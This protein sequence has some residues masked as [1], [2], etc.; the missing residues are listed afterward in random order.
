MP[1]YDY[2][3]V[4]CEQEFSEFVSMKEELLECKFC[5]SEEIRKVINKIADSVEKS[6]SKYKAKTGDLVNHI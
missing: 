6:I 3:C 2:H 1:I 4:S 5:G